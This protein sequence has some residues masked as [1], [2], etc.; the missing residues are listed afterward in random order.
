MPANSTDLMKEDMDRV[1]IRH[2]PVRRLLPRPKSYE[3]PLVFLTESRDGQLI[4]VLQDATRIAKEQ[5]SCNGNLSFKAR[6][7]PRGQQSFGTDQNVTKANWAAVAPQISILLIGQAPALEVKKKATP[8]LDAMLSRT[9]VKT[10]PVPSAKSR[11]LGKQGA[12]TKVFVVIQYGKSTKKR[13]TIRP[14]KPLENI[15]TT[16]GEDRDV[17]RFYFVDHRLNDTTTVNSFLPGLSRNEA[18]LITAAKVLQIAIRGGGVTQHFATTSNKSLRILE[19]GWAQARGVNC[20]EF[21][22]RYK[23]QALALD[24][25]PDDYGM[26]TGDVIDVV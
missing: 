2:G 9:Y 17:L 16:V 19:K 22:F 3:V 14:S 18:A 6:L 23:G 1:V 21:V 10:P 25:K 7:K 20:G 4:Q 15:S 24:L 12:E 13:F 5:F 11:L 8:S 26:D